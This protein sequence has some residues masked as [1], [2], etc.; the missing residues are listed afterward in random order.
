MTRLLADDFFLNYLSEAGVLKASGL[1]TVI[2][3]ARRD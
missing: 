2:I 1:V 3:Q